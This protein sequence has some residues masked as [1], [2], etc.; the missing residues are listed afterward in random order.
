ME[1]GNSY[2]DGSVVAELSANRGSD[3]GDRMIA[4]AETWRKIEITT[5]VLHSRT[6][7][8]SGIFEL[9]VPYAIETFVCCW[10]AR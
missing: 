1:K 5:S 3:I 7:K 9:C 8:A 6:C 2:I 10:K 4:M